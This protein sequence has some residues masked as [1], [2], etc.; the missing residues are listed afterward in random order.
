MTLHF[1]CRLARCVRTDIAY[2]ASALRACYAMSGTDMAYSAVGL[3][4]RTRFTMSGT[5]VVHDAT[6]LLRDVRY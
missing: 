6:G 1:R 5:D 4:L 2:G 3:R